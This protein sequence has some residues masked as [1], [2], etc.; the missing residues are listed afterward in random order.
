MAG[1]FA[2]RLR[3]FLNGGSEGNGRPTKETMLIVFLSGILIFVIML[4]TN[5]SNSGYS[6]KKSQG[7]ES[8]ISTGNMEN[9][10]QENGGNSGSAAEQYRKGLEKELEEFLSSV[11]GVGDVKVL[12]YMKS[13]QEYVVEKDIPTSSSTSGE[14]SELRK[15]EATVYTRNA[16]G[17]EESPFGA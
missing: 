7:T 1:K 3:M 8:T 2:N 12:I 6:K 11:A 9:L 10:Q 15:E 13:S 5:K 16:D 4:P 14:S 17:N